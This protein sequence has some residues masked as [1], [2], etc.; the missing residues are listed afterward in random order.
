MSILEPITNAETISFKPKFQERY[1]KLTDWEAF[2]CY[3]LAFLRRCIRINTV[4]STVKETKASIE[5]KGWN[6]TPVP[7]NKNG[8]WIDH[9]DRRDVGNLLEHKTGKIYVQEAASMIPPLILNPQPGDIVLDMCAAPGSKTTQ[10]AAMME[11]EGLVVANDY[12]GQRLQSLGIN[13]QRSGFTNIMVTLMDGNRFHGFEFDKILAD[14]PCSGTGTIRKSLKTINI[15]N[16]NMITKLAK[17]QKKLAVNAFNNLKV[18]GEMV[19]STCSVEPEENEGVVN[20]L[21]NEFEN[22][23]IVQVKLPGLKTSKPIMEFLGVKYHK[24]VA[25]TIRIWPQDN[26]TEGFYVAKIRKN[27]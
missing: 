20:H 10:M 15:W 7:W 5:A 3:S 11:N 21:L 6:L 4:L 12:K 8:F 27:S 23:E 19:Y 22:A 9:P 25:K 26:D 18:G 16:P 2:K 14:V 17:A 24:D 13:L 1:E